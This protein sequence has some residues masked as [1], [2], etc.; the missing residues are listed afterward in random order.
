[1]V[2]WWW[3]VV[4]GMCGVVVCG[5][6][7][8]GVVLCGAVWCCVVWCDVMWCGVVWCGVE[9]CSVV[10]C[11]VVW[12]GEVRWCAPPGWKTPPHPY[13]SI[14]ADDFV[15]H[16]GLPFLPPRPLSGV[17]AGAVGHAGVQP[18]QVC[19]ERA[20]QQVVDNLAGERKQ[21]EEGGHLGGATC[22]CSR[23]GLWVSR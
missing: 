5:A 12:R 21:Q 22:T 16:L 17:A 11:G 15:P 2:W 3:C 6:V 4:C 23:E 20:L 10:W 18:G 7:R 9:K 14:Q 1:M 8:C 13:R 19:G